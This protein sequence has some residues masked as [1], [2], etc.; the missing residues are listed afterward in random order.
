MGRIGVRVGGLWIL[1]AV[2]RSLKV[3]KVM[4]K[5]L[6]LVVF[7]DKLIYCWLIHCSPNCTRLV[8]A[9]N[10]GMTTPQKDTV[11]RSDEVHREF[12]SRTVLELSRTVFEPVLRCL[13]C[14]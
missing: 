1:L 2:S 13:G 5:V 12:I 7:V 14:V 6:L 11:L 3:S 4:Y 9:V 10:D 8:N